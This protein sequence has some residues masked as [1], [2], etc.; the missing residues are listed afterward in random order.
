MSST[1]SSSGGAPSSGGGGT[2]GTSAERAGEFGGLRRSNRIRKPVAGATTNTAKENAA[3]SWSD[4]SGAL[5]A[6]ADDGDTGAPWTEA[7]VTQFYHGT[8]PPQ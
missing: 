3:A 8:P 7:E 4:G 2:A 1:S 5:A 6:G